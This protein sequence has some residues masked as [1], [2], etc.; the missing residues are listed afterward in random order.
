MPSPSGHM[1]R[2]ARYKHTYAY[3]RTYISISKCVCVRTLYIHTHIQLSAPG[4]TVS[5]VGSLTLTFIA[6]DNNNVIK[7]K[8]NLILLFILCT[9]GVAFTVAPLLPHNRGHMVGPMARLCSP[10]AT[11]SSQLPVSVHP[12]V[13][14][15]GQLPRHMPISPGLSSGLPTFTSP[16]PRNSAFVH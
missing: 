14:G 10:S 3:T 12:T 7:E 8:Y 5:F 11:L 6:R 1:P 2:Y 4:R 13:K 15:E 9:N 16:H